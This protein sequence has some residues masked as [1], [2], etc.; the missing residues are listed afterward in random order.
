MGLGLHSMI[1]MK[2]PV[3]VLHRL[4]Y[5]ISYDLVCRIETAQAELSQEL[6]KISNMLPLTPDHEGRHGRS[7]CLHF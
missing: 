6:L 1:D 4:G 5:S 3:N 2:N 7:L